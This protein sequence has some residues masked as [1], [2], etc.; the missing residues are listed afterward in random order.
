VALKAVGLTE[1][2]ARVDTALSLAADL[3]DYA[4]C[5]ILALRA[6]IEI[7]LAALRAEGGPVADF[8]GLLIDD[9]DDGRRPMTS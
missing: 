2:Q 8:L 5:G 1:D 4:E 3:V 6:A 9:L 7:D